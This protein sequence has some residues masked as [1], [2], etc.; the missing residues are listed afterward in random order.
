MAV[1]TFASNCLTA[2][3]FLEINFRQ[4]MSLVNYSLTGKVFSMMLTV[5][6]TFGLPTVR[7]LVG[8]WYDLNEGY[9]CVLS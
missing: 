3:I 8:L 5:C 4:V 1:D 2:V 6:V 9:K 7:G